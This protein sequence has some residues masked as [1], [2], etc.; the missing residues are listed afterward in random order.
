MHKERNRVIICQGMKII[1]QPLLLAISTWKSDPSTWKR[2][3]GQEQYSVITIE[4]K[5]SMILTV[6]A[7]GGEA[8]HKLAEA[9]APRFR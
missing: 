5:S 6:E 3:I 1:L 8:G 7:F 9:T 4:K 2:I